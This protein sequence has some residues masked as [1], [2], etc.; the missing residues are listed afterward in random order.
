MARTAALMELRPTDRRKPR[1]ARYNQ[2]CDTSPDGDVSMEHILENMKTTP[3]EEVLKRITSLPPNRQGKVLD[4]R[5]Q[6]ADGTYEVADR[7]DTVIERVREAIT[8]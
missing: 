7:L 1:N 8:A 3:P 2:G 5:R 4:I 6:I